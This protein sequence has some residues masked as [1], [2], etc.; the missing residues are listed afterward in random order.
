MY[1]E[2]GNIV[3]Q[4]ITLR[5]ITESKNAEEILLQTNR[6]LE[7]A[8]SRAQ[9]MTAQAEMANRAKSEFLANMSHE[10][11]TPLNGIIGF[12]D[13]LMQSELSTKQKHYMRTVYTSANSL[14]DII[15]DVLDFSKIEAGKLELDPQRTEIAELLGVITDIVKYRAQEKGLELKLTISEDI[16]CLVTVDHIRLRQILV[17]LLSNAIKFTEEGKIELKV[18]AKP[19]FDDNKMEFIFSVTDT[20]IGIEEENKNRIFESFSQ[21]DGSITRKYGGTGLGLTISNSL[22]EMMGSKLELESKLGKGSTFYFRVK[23]PVEDGDNKTNQK[24]LC[25][26]DAESHTENRKCSILVAEDNDTNMELACIIISGFLPGAEILKAENGIEAVKIF[27]NGKKKEQKEIDL[28]LMDVQMSEMNGHDATM[29][30]REIEKEIGGHV[31]IVALTASAFKSEK[32]MCIRSG[33]DDYITKPVVTDVVHNILNKWLYNDKTE[34]NK[35]TNIEY[36]PPKTDYESLHFDKI[37]L[38]NSIQGDD[39][40]Y[41]RLSTMA[42]RSVVSNLEEMVNRYTDQDLQGVKENAHRMKGVSLNIGFNILATMAKELEDSVENSVHHIPE[43]LE[44]MENE[45]EL[46]KLE[47]E[48]HISVSDCDTMI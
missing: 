35:E 33:M 6:D 26:N 14:L 43:M 18:E 4:M 21:A 16:P 12:S 47:I 44:T 9:F 5:D 32:D 7:E 17:N 20:G 34:E 39:E 10:I 45:I 27:L 13:I 15:N 46:I 23:L 19:V 38:M 37:R 2:E 42:L 41:R 3:G 22:L 31:P 1:S 28:I 48:K 11:R 25:C 40:T 36:T 30:I 29:K 24:Q 8:T